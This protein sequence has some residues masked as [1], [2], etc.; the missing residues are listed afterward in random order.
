MNPRYKWTK[1]RV[2]SEPFAFL[3]AVPFVA[4]GFYGFSIFSAFFAFCGFWAFCCF[5]LFGFLKKILTLRPTNKKLA[6]CT[7][8]KL[9][10]RMYCRSTRMVPPL[11][12][13]V[14]QF[15]NCFAICT[16]K[17]YIPS[18]QLSAIKGHNYWSP[19]T[20]WKAFFLF[21]L[22]FFF[23]QQHATTT[24]NTTRP[25]NPLPTPPSSMKSGPCGHCANKKS[26]TIS[27]KRCKE[28]A[29]R[30]ATHQLEQDSPGHRTCRK[31]TNS[32]ICKVPQHPSLLS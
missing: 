25:P 14:S 20:F 6:P 18:A 1:I 3:S 28:Q 5:W 22:F 16:A 30:T 17:L 7:F 32:A 26:T 9:G 2:A 19:T 12:W 24:T 27:N 13:L 4:F 23:G 8:Q 29:T 11:L 31:T 15:R 10:L 21:D